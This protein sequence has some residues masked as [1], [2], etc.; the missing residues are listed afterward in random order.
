MSSRA[1]MSV[2]I[3]FL[4]C[5]PSLLSGPIAS[6]TPPLIKNKKT[7]LDES[8]SREG[9]GGGKQQDYT[10]PFCMLAAGVRAEPKGE[11]FSAPT[12]G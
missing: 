6:P 5:V 12:C 3:S 7:V 2:A 10:G 11:T 4:P 1:A 9:G 8:V